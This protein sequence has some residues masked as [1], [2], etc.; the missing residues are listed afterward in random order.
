MFRNITLSAEDRLIL[1][2]R[3]RAQSENKSLNIVFREWLYRY[4][5][6]KR[7]T[8]AYKNIMKKL[9]HVRVGGKFSREDLNER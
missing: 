4:V 6:G 9:S 7:E 3:A 8:G 1:Q 5:L 2:A